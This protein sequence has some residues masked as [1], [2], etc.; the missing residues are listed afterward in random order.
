MGIGRQVIIPRPLLQRLYIDKGLST[1]DIAKE[2][3][4]SQDTVVRRLHEYEIPIR[5]RRKSLPIEELAH[6]Y[7]EAGLGVKELAKRYHCSHTTV[8]DRLRQLGVLASKPVTYVEPTYGKQQKIISFYNN[9]QSAS[10]IARRLQ[11][12][13]WTVLTTLRRAG[14]MIR[15]SNKRIYVNVKELVYLYTQRHMSTTE[16]AT[17]YK[18]KPATVAER[19]KEAGIH[20]RGNQLKLNTYDVCLRYQQGQS[21]LQIA[22]E[23]G[24][25]YSAVRRRLDQWQGY[26]GVRKES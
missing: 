4:C 18:V 3:H 7:V 8:A 20:L 17:L 21:P 24:C 9:G 16:L 15:H 6:L 10:W 5:T 22:E 13:R 1:W 12:S 11:L 25:S 23:L 2:L 26:R 19:L 14:V